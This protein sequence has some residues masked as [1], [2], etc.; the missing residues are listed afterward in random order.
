MWRYVTLLAGAT[1]FWTMAA[2]TP[3]HAL[4]IISFTESAPGEVPV[5]SGLYPAEVYVSGHLVTT[6]VVTGPDFATGPIELGAPGPGPI[7][8]PDTSAAVLLLDRA[9]ST[10][11]DLVVF[12]SGAVVY[13][14]HPYQISMISF[15]SLGAAA[16]PNL[17]ACIP[18]DVT[19][20]TTVA[21]GGAED[22]TALFDPPFDLADIDGIG[23]RIVVSV[24]KQAIPEPASG[25][26]VAT[27]LA[28]LAG[29]M[30]IRRSRSG[31]FPGSK[32][33]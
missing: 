1:L 16:C 30:V 19:P 11:S 9:T 2:A 3:G 33:R 21:T 26:L 23:Y 31:G 12:H 10:P 28:G 6:P 15:Y 8:P 29:I 13:D 7:E 17:I 4:Q 22:I 14:V 5:V 18:P 20:A 24:P 25:T 27:A 32:T